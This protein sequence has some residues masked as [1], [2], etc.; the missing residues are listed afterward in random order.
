LFDLSHTFD[1][2]LRKGAS[3]RFDTMPSS[4]IR[5]TCS[6]TVGP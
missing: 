2:A 3:V 1:G 5:Q 6:N 4:P